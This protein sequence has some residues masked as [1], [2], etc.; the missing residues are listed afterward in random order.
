[1][2]NLTHAIRRAFQRQPPHVVSIVGDEAL[3]SDWTTRP[4][5][6]APPRRDDMPIIHPR[7]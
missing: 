2:K 6:D 4:I 3:M 1:M 5:Q 7:R